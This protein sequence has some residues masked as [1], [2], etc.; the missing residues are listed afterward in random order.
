MRPRRRTLTLLA[1]LVT[2]VLLAAACGGG[3]SDNKSSDNGSTNTSDEGKPVSGGKVT[4]ALEGGT[5][6]FCIPRAQ[7]AISG[8]L[9]VEA[10][11][12]TLTVPTND[13]DVYAPYLA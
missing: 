12:D 5:T 7:L 10:V 8:I 3:G 4:Y 13:P 11:Y 2:L 1:L 9:V 6:N